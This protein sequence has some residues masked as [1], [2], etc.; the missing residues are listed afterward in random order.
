MSNLCICSMLPHVA[1][2]DHIELVV[3]MDAK[4][5]APNYLILHICC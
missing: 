5:C 1:L 2:S 3:Y 4:V